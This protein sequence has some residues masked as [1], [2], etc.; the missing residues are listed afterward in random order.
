MKT[1]MG[2]FFSFCT[3]E[4]Q[5]LRGSLVKTSFLD[6]VT[7]KGPNLEHQRARHQMIKSNNV[8]A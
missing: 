1:K 2:F 7:S 3:L 5:V 6:A 4:H 8:R